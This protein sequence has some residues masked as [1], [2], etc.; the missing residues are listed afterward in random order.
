MTD[1]DIREELRD[2]GDSDEDIDSFFAEGGADRIRDDLRMRKAL[3]RVAAEVKPIA[4][5]LHEAREAIWT[6]GQD[7]PAEPA[8]L[9]TPGS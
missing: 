5:E 3:D 4:P 6:P 1:D 8:K 7:Q 2:G 9:W